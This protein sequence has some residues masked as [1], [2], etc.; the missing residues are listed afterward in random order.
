MTALW[1]L[2]AASLAEKIRRREVSPVEVLEA[3]VARIEKLEPELNAFITVC[4][5]NALEAARAAEA[6]VMRGET[7]GPLHGVPF[8]V[9][10][11]VN[12]AGVRT[13]FGSLIHE[14]NVP[15]QD[16]VAVARLK[17][18]G[19]VLVGKTTTP[20]FGHKPLTEA[21][22]F[23][24]TRNAWAADRT[25]GGS[26]GGAAVA[27]ASGM[28]PLAVSTD[29]GGSTRIPAAC[30]GVLGFKQSLG[31][32]PHDQTPDAFGNM[33]YIGP[34][35][36]TVLD[37][38]LMMQAM[39]GPHPS[40][41]HSDGVPAIDFLAA[42]QD[43]RALA[44]KRIAWRPYLGN[45]VCDEEVLAAAER[46]ARLFEDAGARLVPMADDFAPTEPIWLVLTQSFWHA[47]FADLLPEWRD[48]MTPTLVRGVEEGAQYSARQLQDATHERTRIFRQVQG[49]F[50]AVDLIVTP[51]LTRTAIPIDHDF[52]K[53]I[54]IGGRPVDTARKAWYPYTHP[55]NLT[56]HPAMTV[57]CGFARDGLPMAVQIVG[58]RY[59]D[60]LVISAARF[61]EE[62]QPWAGRWPELPS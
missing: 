16:A 44:G 7:L 31:V 41:P 50:E 19:A 42:A 4:V 9:K 5:P 47:R 23:G 53:P 55:L 26:S 60:A 6:K 1:Q 45:S 10:D 56:G 54:E 57:P 25:S 18:A 27:V 49:W 21:P 30:N 34:T 3:V 36:R 29:G 14:D 62:A 28:A 61:L 59:E 58:R 39:A 15:K 43:T 51:T 12:T 48:R 35:T 20:E 13:T 46:T 52:Y 33:S 22:L 24:R 37:A 17:A 32:V 40:D 2:P 11:L 8:T 38:A